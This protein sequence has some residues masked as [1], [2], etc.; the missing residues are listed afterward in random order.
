MR[1]RYETQNDLKN[2]EQVA[3]VLA[4]KWG[5]VAKKLPR[6][7]SFD[8]ALCDH[9]EGV[10]FNERFPIKA[11]AEFKC[12]D[13]VSHKFDSSIVGLDKLMEAQR[14]TEATGTMVL[15]VY[16][17]RDGIY[18]YEFGQEELHTTMGGRKDRG[19]WQDHNPVVHIPT[20]KLRPL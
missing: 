10:N 12:R 8:Y 20:S 16:E 3:E 19:D 15:M 14:I 18:Y 9:V 7:Y 17:Y 11:M 1:P 6:S 13:Y 2:E 5:V 4:K